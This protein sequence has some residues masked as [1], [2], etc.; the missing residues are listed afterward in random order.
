MTA[1]TIPVPPPRNAIHDSDTMLVGIGILMCWRRK[2]RWRFAQHTHALQAGEPEFDLLDAVA[3]QLPPAGMLVGWNIARSLAPILLN[4]AATAPPACACGFLTRWQGLLKGGVF[5]M[6]L[7]RGRAGFPTLATAA[8]DWAIYAPTWRDEDIFSAW[9]TGRTDPLR[10]DLADEALALWRMHVR[11]EGMARIDKAEATD[12]WVAAQK[13]SDLTPWTAEEMGSELGSGNRDGA[14][15][16][17][18]T[19]RRS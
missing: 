2:G 4:V 11:A 1:A 5:D 6:A 9:A 19:G 16:P 18:P 17:R 15:N 7:P 12:A 14:E 3:A 13:A 10:R 8:A